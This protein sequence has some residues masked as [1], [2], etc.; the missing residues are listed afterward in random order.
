MPVYTEIT[1][2]ELLQRL[3]AKLGD[4]G[5][6][7]WVE[8]EL[9][10][11]VNEALATWQSYSGYWTERWQVE[12]GNNESVI[13]LPSKPGSPLAYTA[14][15]ADLVTRIKQTLLEPGSSA[16][17][18]LEQYPTGALDNL[19][20]AIR[21]A[22]AKWLIETGLITNYQELAGADIVELPERNLEIRH[23]EWK[24]EPSVDTATHYYTELRETQSDQ[25]RY[26]FYYNHKQPRAYVSLSQPVNSVRLYPPPEDI[27][28]LAIFNLQLPTATALDNS[29]IPLPNSLDWVM[30]YAALQQLFEYDG[31]ARDPYRAEYCQRRYEDSLVLGRNFPGVYNCWLNGLPLVVGGV[32]DVAARR[33]RWHSD[34]GTPRIVGTVSWNHLVVTPIPR[35]GDLPLTL[36]LEVQS[37]PPL[38]SNLTDVIQLPKEYHELLIDFAV[39][40]AL[41]KT[42]GAEFAASI[43]AYKDLLEQA[44]KFNQRL[45]AR[46]A[47]LWLFKKRATTDH[48]S[49]PRYADSKLQQDVGVISIGRNS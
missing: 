24:A 9:I 41:L 43:P 19:R 48:Q 40:L 49:K 30:K 26:S 3:A 47:D 37:R 20:S 29:P 44:M 5:K 8:S 12:L 46:Q 33:P 23:A 18:W 1:L 42:S 34:R 6:V 21:N 17:D 28:K 25:L 14:T 35:T 15:S 22:Y 16:G 4:P 13:D 45:Q 27:G 10:G 39:H 32:K 7:F 2:Q 31:Q 36:D 38:L 11:Y